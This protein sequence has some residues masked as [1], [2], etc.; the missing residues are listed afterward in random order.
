MDLGSILGPKM[1]N[2]GPQGGCGSGLGGVGDALGWED[3][4]K[5]EKTFFLGAPWGSILGPK[6]QKAAKENE[7]GYLLSPWGSLGAQKSRFEEGLR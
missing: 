3:I 4:Q 2:N 1:L 7:Y 6:I 5:H